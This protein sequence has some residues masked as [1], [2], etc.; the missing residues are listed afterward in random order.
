LPDEV[1]SVLA[2][3]E[4]RI[5]CRKLFITSIK[6]EKGTLR[7][8][9][10]RLSK[11]SVDKVVRMVKESS[12]R[13]A[14]DPRMPNFLLVKTGAIGLREKSEFLKDRLAVLVS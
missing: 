2:L 13:I 14:L 5:I 10:S 9:F 8:E 6:E 1:Q 4:I 11:V 7:V 3:A 12:G